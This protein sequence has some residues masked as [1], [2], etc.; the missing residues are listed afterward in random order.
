MNI[1]WALSLILCCLLAGCE[2][3]PESVSNNEDASS[4]IDIGDVE[5]SWSEGSDTQQEGQWQGG[6]ITA[7]ESPFWNED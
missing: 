3:D 4:S 5:V 6:A 1:L 2:T 7:P